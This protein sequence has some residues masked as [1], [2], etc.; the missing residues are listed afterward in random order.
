MQRFE[1][2]K[3]K[4]KCK[5]SKESSLNIA[6]DIEKS[7]EGKIGLQIIQVICSKKEVFYYYGLY[8]TPLYAAT[9]C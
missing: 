5:K 2:K 1:I 6:I 3:S 9:A 8:S 7:L 4:S